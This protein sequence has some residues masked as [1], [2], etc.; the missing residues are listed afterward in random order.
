[1]ED[2]KALLESLLWEYCKYTR[3]EKVVVFYKNGDVIILW[4]GLRTLKEDDGTLINKHYPD[5]T[6]RK[7][8]VEDI[9]SRIKSFKDKIRYEEGKKNNKIVNEVKKD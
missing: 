2:R 1:M 5:F 7:F 8:P 4:L 6:M 3:W 9:N